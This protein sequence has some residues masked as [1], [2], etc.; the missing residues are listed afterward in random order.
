M[1]PHTNIQ[2]KQIYTEWGRLFDGEWRLDPDQVKS[3]RI[4]L[5]TEGT[6]V[7]EVIEIT[8]EPGIAVI[9]FALKDT[10]EKWGDR[11]LE[12]ALD[13]TCEPAYAFKSANLKPF[14]LS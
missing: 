6:G 12:L 1:D 9:A 2:Q 7:A 13:G 10:C 8:P 5:E 3:A 4:L 11:T 14:S